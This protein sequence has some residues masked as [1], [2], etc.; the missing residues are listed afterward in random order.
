MLLRG[1][2]WDGTQL[3]TAAT[4][5]RMHPLLAVLPILIGASHNLCPLSLFQCL[6]DIDIS[7]LTIWG[8]YWFPRAVATKYHKLGGL[9][10]QIWMVSQFWRLEV[11]NQG[12]GRAMLPPKPEG[13][14]PSLPLPASGPLRIS[15]LVDASV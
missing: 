13:E 10:Q 6:L 11:Q 1:S 2:R 15:W 8:F 7:S 9:E 14:D 4:C 5:S 12:V 3:P